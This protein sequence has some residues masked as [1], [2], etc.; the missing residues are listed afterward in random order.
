MHWNI[1]QINQL[2]HCLWAG[3]FGPIGVSAIFYLY[4]SLDFLRQVKVEGEVRKDA[5]RLEEVFMIVV[6]FLTICSIVVH[7]LSVPL[8][9]LGYHLPRTLSRSAGSR[10]D[11]VN[12]NTPMPF[13]IQDHVE[14]QPHQPERPRKPG[15]DPTRP[16]FRI[17]GSI[18]RHMGS[19]PVPTSDTTSV[20]SSALDSPDVLTRKTSDTDPA[21]EEQKF[22]NAELGRG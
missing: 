5:A 7:G 6:W 1:P 3:F 13:H 22:E 10:K 14:N 11:A 19:E 4:V 8:G 21:N 18:I 12:L 9:K 15:T 20:E 16:V 17:G 2:K